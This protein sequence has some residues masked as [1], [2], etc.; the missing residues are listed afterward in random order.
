MRKPI[1]LVALVLLFAASVLPASTSQP[2]RRPWDESDGPSSASVVR[3]MTVVVQKI[4]P[5]NTLQ[6]IDKRTE[7]VHRIQLAGDVPIRARSKKDFDGRRKLTFADLAVGQRI[8]LT[9]RAAD[10]KIVSLKVVKRA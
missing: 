4:G 9:Y 2:G 3:T 1:L 5:D 7:E 10:G 6:V 8:K